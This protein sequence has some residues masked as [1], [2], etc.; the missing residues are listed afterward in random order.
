M[1]QHMT[2][3]QQ[4]KV[5][6]VCSSWHE[7]VKVTPAHVSATLHDK[8]SARH[9]Q[10]WLDSNSNRVAS[11]QVSADYERA[12]SRDPKQL[13]LTLAGSCLPKLTSIRLQNIAVQVK[14]RSSSARRTQDSS[15]NQRHSAD[16]TGPA[17]L[18]LQ[19]VDLNDCSMRLTDLQVLWQAT[20]LAR[21]ALGGLGVTAASRT[22][23]PREQLMQ[24][25][26]KGG[27]TSQKISQAMR[28]LL[29][30]APFLTELDLMRQTCTGKLDLAKGGVLSGMQHLRRISLGRKACTLRNLSALPT[31]LA[32][33]VLEGNRKAQH[34]ISLQHVSHVTALTALQELQL[35]RFSLQPAILTSFPQLQHLSLNYVDI[36]V[37]DSAGQLIGRWSGADD[38]HASQASASL[39]AAVGQL[40]HLQHLELSGVVFDACADP[41]QYAAL[42]A[43]SHLTKLVICSQHDE[44]ALQYMLPGGKQLPHLRHLQ[45][46]PTTGPFMS[47]ADVQRWVECCP[48]MTGLVVAR[49]DDVAGVARAPGALL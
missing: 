6:L 29:S 2:L 25:A 46:D 30:K 44:Q 24:I 45:L 38:Y 47:S 14:G 22:A 18:A 1:L 23:S 48:A 9:L 20:A 15:N 4:L 11:L 34:S 17:F 10:D 39:L 5:S 40:Q 28:K 49:C 16:S 13:P 37:Q 36:L 8:R 32:A 35:T 3:K 33:L 41:Q 19:E 7:A 21:L 42:T 31:S 27:S 12:N 43:S 26:L